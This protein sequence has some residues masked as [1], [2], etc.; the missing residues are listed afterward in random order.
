MNVSR[1]AFVDE[2]VR[3]DFLLCAVHLPAARCRVVGQELERLRRPG[4]M[5]IHMTKEDGRRKR[6]LVDAAV[7]S[8]ADAHIE[9]VRLS[10]EVSQRSARDRCLQTSIPELIRRGVTDLTVESCDQDAADRHV[11]ADVLVGRSAHQLHYAHVRPHEEPLLWLADIV[12]W[13]YGAGGDWRRRLTGMAVELHR[14]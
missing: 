12:V 5:R 6:K 9:V 4:Q 2:S 11:I 8:G 13:A 1:R 3:R 10:R 7:R 14:A